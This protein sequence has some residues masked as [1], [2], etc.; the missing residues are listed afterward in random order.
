MKNDENYVNCPKI[1]ATFVQFCYIDTIYHHDVVGFVRAFLGE[2][3]FT[4]YTLEYT[5]MQMEGR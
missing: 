5:V 2:Q 3:P 1:V 4:N